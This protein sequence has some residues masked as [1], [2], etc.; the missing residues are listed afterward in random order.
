M[1]LQ[2]KKTSLPAVRA[3]LLV[4]FIFGV[5]PSGAAEEV[6]VVRRSKA[7]GLSRAAAGSAVP[8]PRSRSR[9]ATMSTS[10]RSLPP[11]VTT[12]SRCR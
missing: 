11:S 10:A 8:V 12:S 2:R 7:G 6:F 4:A 3:L 1:L 9:R 5:A